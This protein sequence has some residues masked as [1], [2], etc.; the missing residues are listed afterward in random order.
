MK[1][2]VKTVK[3]SLD[4]DLDHHQI[5]NQMLQID[6]KICL[7][8][9]LPK[10]SKILTISTNFNDK[11]IDFSKLCKE[12]YRNEI[13]NWVKENNIRNLDNNSGLWGIYNEF[14][15]YCDKCDITIDDKNEIVKLW[16]KNKDLSE[17]LAN[18]YGAE[19][20]II[21]KHNSINVYL[22]I[23]ANLVKYK[24]FLNFDD[25]IPDSSLTFIKRIIGSVFIPF[26]E[27]TSVNICEIY[28]EGT[29]D[30]KRGLLFKLSK[31]YKESLYVYNLIMSPDIDIDE[32]GKS[33]VSVIAEAKKMVPRCDKAF[34]AIETSVDIFKCNFGDYY[35][36]FVVTK[37]PT[38]I[39]ENYILDICNEK[40]NDDP[41]LINQFRR[42]VTTIRHHAQ[43]NNM[44]TPEIKKLFKTL[45]DKYTSFEHKSAEM[46][47]LAEEVPEKPKTKNQKR[48]ERRKKKN[49]LESINI[50]DAMSKLTMPHILDTPEAELLP[51]AEEL[52]SEE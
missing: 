21:K 51:E 50:E 12:Q 52:P 46:P 11:L 37:N 33:M 34:N 49:L 22:S 3:K 5:F 19:F 28:N 8:K 30:T 26:N 44:M 29:I 4:S 6:T 40:S 24:S 13:V 18:V 48:H 14:V 47:D 23:C 41:V 31:I 7:D 35:K 25:V 36:D 39:M 32:F 1:A 15:E 42:I 10:M 27:I 45:E 2:R 38:S 17:E 9:A 43:T 20:D 16:C